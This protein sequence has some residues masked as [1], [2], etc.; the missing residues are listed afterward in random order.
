[1]NVVVEKLAEKA[2][3]AAISN[4]GFIDTNYPFEEIV[5]T[6]NGTKSVGLST[7]NIYR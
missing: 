6:S 4:R 2:L 7:L 1:M 5:L 3:L